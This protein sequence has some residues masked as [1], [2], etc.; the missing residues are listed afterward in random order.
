MARKSGGSSRRV[1]KGGA[2]RTGVSRKKGSARQRK[3][4]RTRNVGRGRVRG[5]QAGSGGKSSSLT[6]P[7]AGR[8]LGVALAG[9]SAPAG[10]RGAWEFGKA[11]VV[12]KRKRK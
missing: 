3:A 8:T 2:K 4:L 7:P 9:Q 12:S 5:R 11:K 6:A 1:L 10:E